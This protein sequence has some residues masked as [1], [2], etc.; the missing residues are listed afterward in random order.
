MSTF[1]NPPYSS[2]QMKVYGQFGLRR[3]F[4]FSLSL[5]AEIKA[6]DKRICKKVPG[7]WANPVIKDKKRKARDSGQVQCSKIKNFAGGVQCS[8]K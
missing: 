8:K 5:V 4:P 6:S 3:R 7:Q 2:S 1:E